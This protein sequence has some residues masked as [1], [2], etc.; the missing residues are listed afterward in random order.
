MRLVAILLLIGLAVWIGYSA[1]GGGEK[2]V[3][4]PEGI[5]WP[6]KVG[7]PYP[8]LALYDHTGRRVQLSEL[9]GKVLL[10]EPVGMTCAACNAFS[11]GQ[12]YGG[13]QGIKPQHGLQSIEAYFPHVTGGMSLDDPRIVFV[14]LIIYNMRMQAPS[15]EEVRLWAE[16]FG[17]DKKPNVLVLASEPYLLGKVSRAMIPGFQ[18]V[19]QN[20]ILRADS[21]GHPPQHDLFG[22]ALPLIPQ[23]LGE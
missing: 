10:I 3:A 8:D 15:A 5:Q 11:G 12:E 20:F 21:T 7:Q 19:D 23:L 22:T 17:L 16:H 18:V 2:A 6:P 14:Q 1:M 13:F 9:R 4:M